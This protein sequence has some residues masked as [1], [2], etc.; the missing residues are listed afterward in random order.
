MNPNERIKNIKEKIL[1]KKIKSY[2]A[3]IELNSLIKEFISVPREDNSKRLDKIDTSIKSIKPV[4]LDKIVDK[5][6]KI[7]PVVNINTIEIIDLLKLILKKESINVTTQKIEWPKKPQDAI[8][9][10]LTEKTKK[11]FYNA[12][13][14]LPFF[15][16]GGNNN[17]SGS[18]IDISGLAT[19][20]LQQSLIDAINNI[21]INADSINLNTDDL[22]T[23]LDAIKSILE[24]TIKIEEQNPLDISGLATSAK[25]LPD[26]HNVTVSNQIDQPT[27]PSD[28]QPV[29]EQNPIDVSGLATS[30]KQLPDNHQVAV[31]NIASTPVITG[32]ATSSNQTNG[33]QQTK[34]KETVPTDSTKNNASLALGYTGSNLTTL[35]KTISGV[36]YQKTLTYSGS[37]LTNVGV[38]TQI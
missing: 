33:S 9:V 12:I 34:I 25:Q 5:L 13:S 16:G 31:S 26:N 4:N 15:G 27:T 28:T 24:G 8:P 17:G 14:S 30:A 38:W 3:L 10:V 32:F 19:K 37:T 1:A 20:D 36:Q 11:E 6:D 23:L 18:S 22:E 7:N 35:T 2:D 29:E 21:E